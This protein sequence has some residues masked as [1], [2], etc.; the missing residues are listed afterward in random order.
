MKTKYAAV[1]C[2]FGQWPSH[3]AWWLSSCQYNAGI[4]FFLVTDIPVVGYK[5]P[6]NVRILKMSFSEVKDLVA[7]KFPDI[8]ISLNRP[9]KLCDFKTAYGYIF[10]EHL[11]DYAYWGFYDI[12]TIWGDIE[13]FIPSNEENR[14]VKI[15]P[16]GHLC[17]IRNEAPWIKVFKLVNTVAG[18]SC[19]NNMEGKQV[20]AWQECFSKPESFYY[21]EEGGLEPLFS[22]LKE[23]M[24]TGVDFD[25]IL[26]PWRFNH[27]YSINFPEKSRN[28][29]YGYVEGHLFRF[30]L[31]GWKVKK[32]EISYLHF[33][34]RVLNIQTKT[35]SEF[36][37]YPN[38]IVQKVQW[39]LCS[40]LIH[41]RARYLTHVLNR[42]KNKLC[43]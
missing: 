13:K 31:K 23:T 7:S 18:T 39:G 36:S 33:S 25:N 24:Y 11:Q 21:D 37:I 10:Q 43:K 9:Y 3:F 38:R 12:D 34:K 29:V 19:R 22:S 16:C 4:T 30:Y 6:E 1:C 14:L 20:V 27:F 15:F 28:L 26:P 35:L 42:I 8:T 40:L 17:F 32:E 5:V 41:G 2:Y